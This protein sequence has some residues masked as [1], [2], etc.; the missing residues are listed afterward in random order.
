MKILIL[1]G[2]NL[3]LLGKREPHIYGSDTFED[4]LTVLRR[5][6]PAVEIDY[7]QSNHEGVLID[8]L[9]RV[10]FDAQYIG[11]VINAGGLTHTSIALADAVGGIKTPVVEVHISNIHAR[12]AYRHHSYIAPKAKGSIVGL[13]LKGYQLAIAYLLA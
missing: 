13:G 10:G 6:Y 5:M 7:V 3:N 11:I 9:H 8:T 12:E 4:Y 2:P 1:N